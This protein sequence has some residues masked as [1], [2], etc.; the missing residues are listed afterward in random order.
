MAV[1]FVSSCQRVLRRSL[2]NGGRDV[3]CGRD[4]DLGSVRSRRVGVIVPV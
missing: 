1:S 3:G 4:D 2:S